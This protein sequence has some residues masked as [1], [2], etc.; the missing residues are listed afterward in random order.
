MKLHRILLSIVLII[1]LLPVHA[2]AAAENDHTEDIIYYDDGSYILIETNFTNA[3]V[4]FTRNANL[5]YSY[6]NS[7]NVKKWE[8]TLFATFIYDGTTSTCASSSVQVNILDSAWYIVSK[9]EIKDGNT[10][11]GELTMGYKFLGI[12][13]TKKT[14]DMNITCDANG[15]L[16]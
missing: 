16:S 9:E 12:T 11:R 14:I 5:V 8:A 15:N 7:S 6:Y 2:F 13:T 1:A 10:A 3:R 4:G